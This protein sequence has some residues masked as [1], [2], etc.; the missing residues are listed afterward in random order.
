MFCDLKHI[1]C[2]H[3][4]IGLMGHECI[5][6]INPNYVKNNDDEDCVKDDEYCNICWIDPLFASPCIKLTCGDYFHFMF[7]SKY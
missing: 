4:C 6:C 1:E 5:P 2:G 3:N 7:I